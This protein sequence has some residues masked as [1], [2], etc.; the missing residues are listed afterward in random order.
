MLIRI[1]GE[2]LGITSDVLGIHKGDI[3]SVHYWEGGDDIVE[4]DFATL[5]GSYHWLL[6]KA[7]Y[8]ILEPA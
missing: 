5:S 6:T 8:E 4:F 7:Q 1:T 2:G 3:V